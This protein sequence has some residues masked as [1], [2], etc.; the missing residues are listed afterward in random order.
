MV[1]YG[2]DN[3]ESIEITSDTL[4]KFLD[5]SSDEIFIFN[6]DRQ[7]IY[8]NIACE[9][10]HGLKK[11]ELLGRYSKDLFENEYWT[12]SVYPEVYEKKKPIFMI[13]TTNTWAELLTSAIPVLN[14]K[15]EVEL[16]M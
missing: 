2:A 3:S 4:K 10:H 16:Y 8:V 6:K 9:R 14:D 1:L 15:C 5:Y 13:Q 11:E 7:I 12:P